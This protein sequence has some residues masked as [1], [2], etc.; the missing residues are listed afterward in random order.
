MFGFNFD[1]RTLY[2]IIGILVLM[3]LATYGTEGIFS[4]VLSIPAV[5][6]AITIHEFGHAFAAY[7]LGDDTPLRQGR[8]SLNPLDHLDPLG[9]AMLLFAHIGWGKPVQ[10]DP[11]NYNRNISVEKADAIV[12]FAGPLMNFITAIVFAIIYCAIYKF[13]GMAFVT[14]EIGYIIVLIVQSIVTM[15]IGLGVFN[16]IPL[17]PL[18][19]SK[20]FLPVLPYNAKRWLEN[21]EQMFYFLFLILWITGIAGHLIAPIIGAMTDGILKFA[22]FVMGIK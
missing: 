17:P 1:K 10:V 4:L 11:R 15:N 5:L 6:L 21:N 22:M 19:G 16:L 9:I 3:S 8:L 20:I 14:S 13:A 2:I 12:S 7:K 18:D